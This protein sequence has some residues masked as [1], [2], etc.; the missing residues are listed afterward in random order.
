MKEY[1]MKHCPV[2]VPVL[3]RLACGNFAV[4]KL[5]PMLSK[6]PD[7]P[8]LSETLPVGVVAF[9]GR[10]NATVQTRVLSEPKGW[11]ALPGTNVKP[12]RELHTFI[13]YDEADL[14]D[15]FAHHLV[16]IGEYASV[17][18]PSQKLNKWIL[19]TTGR[20]LRTSYG[21]C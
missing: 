8:L 17:N 10:G 6:M 19:A 2:N 13:T 5:S 7:Q 12:V 4:A 15:A 9:S 18:E 3:M 1:E 20:T 14:I 21:T 16:D 11:Y